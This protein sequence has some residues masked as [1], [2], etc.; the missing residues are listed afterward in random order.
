M[1]RLA[2]FGCQRSVVPVIANRTN[3]RMTWRLVIG[4]V[5]LAGSLL[6][7]HAQGQPSFGGIGAV[8]GTEGGKFVI[9]STLP[10]SPAAGAGFPN[11]SVIR[12]I[13]GVSTEEMKL[14]DVV[15]RLRGPIG[16]K[17]YVEFIDPVGGD[18]ITF[19]V[20]REKISAIPSDRA[21]SSLS[22]PGGEGR[23]EEAPTV[24]RN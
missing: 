23:G 6:L 22:S 21:T 14:A 24:T 15:D 16:S 11:G 7:A 18:P 19:P 8:I 3:M 9:R 1:N 12:S 2:E 13:D 20:T 5:A 4:S 10:L 17:V